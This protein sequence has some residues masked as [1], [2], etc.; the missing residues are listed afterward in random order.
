MITDQEIKS[1]TRYL[2][3][4]KEPETIPLGRYSQAVSLAEQLLKERDAALAK[5]EFM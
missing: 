2:D 1:H 3:I 5:A 4:S